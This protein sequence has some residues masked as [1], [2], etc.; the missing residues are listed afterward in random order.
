M[1]VTKST[2][3][4]S[5]TTI[6]CALDEKVPNYNGYYFSDCAIKKP[7]KAAL[8]ADDAKRLWNESCEMTKL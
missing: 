5:F 4:G 3:E 7:S 6:Y 8:N 1:L 2:N